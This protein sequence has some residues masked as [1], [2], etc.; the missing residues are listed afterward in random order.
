MLISEPED[1][2]YCV[3]KRP[4]LAD[5]HH[6][7]HDKSCY[8]CHHSLFVLSRLFQQYIEYGDDNTD[9]RYAK[10]KVYIHIITPIIRL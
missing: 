9:T 6:E 4:Y 2:S 7:H 1:A 8:R 5:D 10:N 3:K